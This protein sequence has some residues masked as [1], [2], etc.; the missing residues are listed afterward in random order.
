[1][2]I[3][4]GCPFHHAQEDAAMAMANIRQQA[5][6]KE[7]SPRDEAI[8]RPAEG[9]CHVLPDGRR[10]SVLHGRL[11]SSQCA[12][13]GRERRADLRADQL[14]SAVVLEP[15][16]HERHLQQVFLRRS[17]HG[18][19]RIQRAAAGAPRGPHDCRL[20]HGG[21]LL[22]LARRTASGSIASWP[23]CACISTGRSIRPCGSTWACITSTA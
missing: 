8:P 10:G 23:G 4:V 21:R 13:Q 1:M 20:G 12:D 7:T 2:F 6:T 9:R 22:R 14:R 11:G 5:A 15:A 16:G 17:G 3:L 19:A 18:R